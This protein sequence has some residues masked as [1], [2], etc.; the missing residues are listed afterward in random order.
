MRRQDQVEE[1][2]SQ[3]MGRSVPVS[4]CK[5]GGW[6]NRLRIF[7]LLR[8]SPGAG[9]LGRESSCAPRRIRQARLPVVSGRSDPAVQLEDRAIA[10][11][12]GA[13]VSE[14]YLNGVRAVDVSLTWPA[15]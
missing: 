10:P 9:N 3:L 14:Q 1:S 2:S 13:G 11:R 4:S 6:R 12:R 5:S 8:R 7:F 15:R